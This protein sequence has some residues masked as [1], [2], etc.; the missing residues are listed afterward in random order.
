MKKLIFLLILLIPFSIKAYD[1]AVVDINNLSIK[2]L[3]EYV[4]KGYLTY[5][6]ITKLYLD[7]IEAYNKQY[8]ALITIN[9]NALE[10]A[11]KL[12]KLYQENGR[13]SMIYGLPVIVKDNIDVKG[14]P[15][16]NGTKALL[17]SIPYENAT[18]VQK[19]IDNGAIVIAKANM[20]EFAFNAAYSYSSFGYVY[21]AFDTNYSSYG[22]SGG[23]AV[24]V[25]SNLAVYALGSDTGSSIR[26]PAS[27]NGVVGIRPS[28]DI[29]SSDGVIKFDSTRDV[30][31]VI[32]K[33][34]EDSAIVLDIIDNE[35]VK[36]T[37]YLSETLQGVTIGV[38]KGFMDP[39]TSSDSV[40]YG[41]TDMFIYNM[42]N[43]SIKTL[44]DLGAKIVYLDSFYLSYKFDATAMCYEF[45]EYIQNTTSKVKSLDDLIK[46]GLYTQY[47]DSYNGYYCTHDY[48]LTDSYKSYIANRNNN[49]NTANNKFESL[50]LDAIIYPTI[51]NELIKI[52]N[53]KS[54][55]L[56]TPSSDIAPLVGF[57][58]ITVPMG[59]NNGLPYG[60]EIVTTS[61][62]E[63][64][65]YKI[66]SSYEN[67]NKVYT[68]PSIAPSLY[69]IKD[70]V[71]TLL[72][73][74]ETYKD[75][76]AYDEIN[77][78]VK[79]FINNYSYNENIV[80]ELISNYENPIETNDESNIKEFNI[81]YI[82]LAIVIIL[83]IIKLLLKKVRK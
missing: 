47:I 32:T 53:A 2:Q 29:I 49:I 52:E 23:S 68:T 13:T 11:K 16:T 55:K 17:D 12:D 6:K 4:D 73:Y 56:H 80:N 34:V 65:L 39:Y 18:V 78:K 15:T 64:M 30:V 61:K 1:E 20:D 31:G 5:E 66:A 37:D 71:T 27:A 19:L 7:R 67:V 36:Y 45:N 82:I 72:N 77:N 43:E 44:E 59:L 24:G 22:S 48:K 38:V 9:E 42:M 26:V 51:K 33:Y 74:Y 75:N 21:N 28:Y 81:I 14:L 60:L 25:A 62:N 3:Q 40:A 57:P 69:E 76:I 50:G 58:A 35:D 70:N 79:E 63:G 46:T 8:N 41:K 83:I 54:S 10:E